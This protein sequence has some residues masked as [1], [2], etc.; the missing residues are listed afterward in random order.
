MPTPVYDILKKEGLALVWVEAAYDIG[1]AK[2]RLEEL[3]GQSGDAYVVFDQRT[4][5]IVANLDSSIFRRLNATRTMNT[6]RLLRQYGGVRKSSS[7]ARTAR[8][9]PRCAFTANSGLVGG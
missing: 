5:Q 9:A 2:V 3:I 6:I 1:A 4:R 8:A 7:I